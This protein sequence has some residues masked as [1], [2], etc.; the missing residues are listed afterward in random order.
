MSC[1]WGKLDCKFEGT[2]KCDTCF[3]VELHYK[4]KESLRPKK[5][6]LA[7]KQQKQDKRQGSYFEYKNHVQNQLVVNSSMTLNSGAT[8]L[9]KGD[10]QIRGLINVMEELKT[11]TKIQAPGKRTFTIQEKWLSKLRQ[12]ARAENMEFYYLKFSFHE[13]DQDIYVI[14]EQDEIM[15]MVHTM[16]EDRKR[17]KLAD[18]KV[19]EANAQK[20]LWMAET[21][22]LRAEIHALTAEL[23]RIK[24]EKKDT[25]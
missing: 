12:E 25:L 16:T 7:R 22:K 20:E 15:S 23:E 9:Q 10:E 8:N 4:P 5:K 19:K 13:F 24:Y 18:M 11:R 1:E 3:S 14:V 6:T 2:E 17:A 21:E